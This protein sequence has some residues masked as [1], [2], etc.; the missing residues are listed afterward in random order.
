[1]ANSGE[2]KSGPVVLERYRLVRQLGEGGMGAVYEARHIHLDSRHA[3]KALRHAGALT[4]DQLQQLE[5]R[6]LREAKICVS[7]RHPNLVPVTDFG[8]TDG[9]PYIVMDFI[10]GTD[11]QH[12]IDERG[13]FPEQQAL[14]VIRDVAAALGALHDKGIIHRDMKPA[15]V[16][17]ERATGRVILTD[18][19]IAKDL[20]S[21]AQLT[22][23]IMGTPAFMAPEQVMDTASAGPDSDVY[24]LGAT[25]FNLLTG[26]PP[27]EGENALTII[28]AAQ[29]NL[30]AFGSLA[31]VAKGRDGLSFSPDVEKLLHDMTTYE[32]KDRIQS[33]KEVVNRITRILGGGKPVSPSSDQLTM[34]FGDEAA[35][36]AQPT[37]R[38]PPSSA[39][40][41]TGRERPPTSPPRPGTQLP[42]GS[43]GGRPPTAQA[44]PTT[45]TVLSAVTGERSR[46]GG[47]AA[48]G[49]VAA[50]IV[51]VLA[52]AGGGGYLAW[53]GGLLGG[54]AGAP[55]EAAGTAGAPGV[56][57]GPEAA[58]PATPDAQPAAQQPAPPAGEPAAKRRLLDA[59]S[60]P[61]R[62][63]VAIPGAR[64]LEFV[65]VP[66]GKFRIGTPSG[67][68]DAEKPSREVE[69]AT[70]FYIGLHEVTVGQYAAFLNARPPRESAL[71]SMNL[72]GMGLVRSGNSWASGEGAAELPARYVSHVMARRF[73]EWVSEL[74]GIEAELPS[75]VEWEYA[76]RGPESRIYPWGNDWEEGLA[77]AGGAEGPRPVGSFPDGRSW[78]GALDMAGN[79]FEWTADEYIK[80]RYEKLPEK[81]PPPADPGSSSG[82]RTIRGGCF[83]ND[84]Y[85]CRSAHRMGMKGSASEKAL[86]FR[87]KV[88]ATDAVLKHASGDAPAG[89]A[90]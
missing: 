53:R 24:A 79:V 33:M 44:R 46:A 70:P 27:F 78:C 68:N 16:M 52:G 39:R 7:I 87:V 47:R 21:S 19:G 84:D 5:A 65:L 2:K 41:P 72:E 22:Q 89:G 3:V 88:L 83:G 69:I 15:N 54:K 34:A 12:V 80:D 49:L 42:S 61:K 48:K 51:L 58:K 1:V 73:C 55:P 8:T 81:D 71:A 75:E 36:D 63:S 56:R 66:P 25:L 57:P 29:Q 74:A 77:C 20:S 32:R 14:Q 43:A 31:G 59:A 76:A 82:F 13:A 85:V 10:D 30:F 50:G 40:P 35:P 28:Q 60:A 26:R 45:R 11:L 86:G 62:L 67:D 23:G 9:V 38:K 6:F 4:P 17:I 37:V 18:L 64:P 90:Q